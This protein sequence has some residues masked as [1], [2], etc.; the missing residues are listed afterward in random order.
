MAIFVGAGCASPSAAVKSA[1]VERSK[2]SYGPER[3]QFGEL[4]VVP[5]RSSYPVVVL[6]HGGFWGARYGLDL[7][8]PLADD[9]AG[10]G[11]AVWNIEYRRVGERGGGWPGTLDD[12]VAALDRLTTLSQEKGFVIESTAVVGHSAGGQLALWLAGRPKQTVAIR[13][14]VGL[15]PV[16]NLALAASADLGGGAVQS[17]LGGTPS[18]VPDRYRVAMPGLPASGTRSVA[19]V[20]ARDD[21]VPS[22]FSTGFET[23]TIDRADHFDLIDPHHAAW[24]AVVTLL[25]E[26]KTT[27]P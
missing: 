20:G 23:I 9:L 4:H 14:A 3:S 21:V 22:E 1:R 6:I 18:E 11:Y 8:S 16:T 7:M 17:L 12:T 25:E 24:S 26:S 27:S 13:L 10:R 5:G 19:I 15:G 2:V